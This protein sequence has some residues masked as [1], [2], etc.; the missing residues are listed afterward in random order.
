MAFRT[1]L[2][3]LAVGAEHEVVACYFAFGA[4]RRGAAGGRDQL[5][6]ALGGVDDVLAASVVRVGQHFLG[7]AALRVQ[8]LDRRNH[9]VLIAHV[10]PF[11]RHVRDHLR[12]VLGVT[13]LG[14]LRLKTLALVAIGRVIVA[15]LQ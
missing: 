15:A 4:L 6:V 9:R 1:G 7:L 3:L 12:C 14:H 2:E 8:R 11:D 5:D 13:R 10:R